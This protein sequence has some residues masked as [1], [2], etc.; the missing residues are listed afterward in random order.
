MQ[1][2]F[3]EATLPTLEEVRSKLSKSWFGS[4]PDRQI[5]SLDKETAG[6]GLLMQR[7]SSEGD[8]KLEFFPDTLT[9]V[10]PKSGEIQ[11]QRFELTVEVLRARNPALAI[12]AADGTRII[13]NG[14]IGA[15]GE[16]GRGNG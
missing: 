14:T 9:V 16:V 1:R 6:L 12:I 3:D 15:V 5:N 2:L 8:L 11:L 7:A 13:S 10:D 4:H